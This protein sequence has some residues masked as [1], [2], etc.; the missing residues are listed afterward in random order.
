MGMSLEI[1]Y[2]RCYSDLVLSLKS[3]DPQATLSHGHP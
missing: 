1:I 2:I 3:W